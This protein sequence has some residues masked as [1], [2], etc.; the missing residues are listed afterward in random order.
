MKIAYIGQKGI[1]TLSGGVERHVEELA[2]RQVRLGHE[3]TVYARKSYQT[4]KKK[5]KKIERP[6]HY[7]GVRIIHIPSIATKN[8]DA[9]TYTFLATFHALFMSFDVVHYQAIGPT[10]LAWIIKWFKRKST[11]VATFHCKDYEHQKWGAFAR[12]Y[13]RFGEWVTCNVPDVTIAVSRSLVRY[14]KQKYNR[15]VHYVPNG[16]QVRLILSARSLSRWKVRPRGYVLSV[17]RL[18][19]HKG[20]H[21]LIEAFKALED[22]NRLPNNYKL[23]IVGGSSQTDE[24]VKYL[25]FIAKGRKNIIFTGELKGRPLHE[26]FTHAGLFVQPSLAEGLSI[27]LLESLGYGLPALVSDIPE[28]KEAIGDAGF[29]FKSANKNDLIKQLSYLINTPRAVEEMR[30]KAK[31]RA[32]QEYHW[33]VIAERTLEV[34]AEALLKRQ[35]HSFNT[36]TNKV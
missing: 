17:S 15:V 13:F 24:Y 22:T 30:V 36:R 28:N 34:Y 26:L 9:I 23:V 11:V 7:K 3:V 35:S 8:L 10:S 21:F 16:S 6:T 27:A 18:V 20:I 1:P 33:D 12:A 2:V 31:A 32:H 25:K 19:R 5:L 14:A 29:T 4:S